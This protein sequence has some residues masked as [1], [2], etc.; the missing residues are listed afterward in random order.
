MLCRPGC[1]CEQQYRMHRLLAFD[2][3]NE[4]R[5][6]FSDWFELPS[7]CVCKFLP[8]YFKIMLV[9]SCIFLIT[10]IYDS[11]YKSNIGKCY[12]TATDNF[13]PRPRKPRIDEN[14]MTMIE[15]PDKLN[16][17]GNK[18]QSEQQNSI[19]NESVRYSSFLTEMIVLYDMNIYINVIAFT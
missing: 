12:E 10:A 16:K 8:L 18:E 3:S 1:K 9:Y 5:G 17:E 11:K 2:P 15:D 4:C 13:I 6:I 7:F 19:E 14:Q